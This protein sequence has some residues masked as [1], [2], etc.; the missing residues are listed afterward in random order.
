MIHVTPGQNKR[1]VVVE[2]VAAVCSIDR[3]KAR[4]TLNNLMQNTTK[5][6][7]VK[8]L[9]SGTHIFTGCVGKAHQVM[10][11]AQAKQLLTFLPRKYTDSI[12]D[13]ALMQAER[14]L[15]GDKSLIPEINA[16]AG[17]NA[18]LQQLVREDLGMAAIAPE[19]GGGV[20]CESGPQPMDVVVDVRE[21]E[22]TMLTRTNDQ[23][24]RTL[25]LLHQAKA[26]GYPQLADNVLEM[27][28]RCLALPTPVPRVAAVSA[29]SGLFYACYDPLSK[30]VKLGMTTKP[31]T[32]ERLADFHTSAPG[33]E[34]VGRVV[35][36]NP[37]LL[38]KR[39][40]KMIAHLREDPR[41]ETFMVSLEHV[42]T[43]FTEIRDYITT[44]PGQNGDYTFLHFSPALMTE[45]SS[46]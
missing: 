37:G 17:S 26:L 10:T 5:G 21:Q 30:R 34:E 32:K 19:P 23:I 45:L 38:E 25:G 11:L 12:L 9:I 15:A 24:E 8:K 46:E 36:K 14:I 33:Y 28:R 13:A 44:T 16:N 22:L 6:P 2:Y 43:M 18:P 39:V 31:T 42:K 40:M 3:K 35:C 1:M 27:Q 7:T 20:L 41:H 29:A 4:K